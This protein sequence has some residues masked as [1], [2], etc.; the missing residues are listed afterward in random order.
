[1]SDA[2]NDFF[3]FNDG[4]NPAYTGDNNRDRLPFQPSV[5]AEGLIYSLSA[6]KE[7]Q[8]KE[9]AD[10]EPILQDRMKMK[11][12]AAIDCDEKYSKLFA[13]STSESPENIATAAFAKCEPLFAD[14]AEVRINPIYKDGAR[15]ERVSDILEAFRDEA[16]KRTIA[17]VIESRARQKLAPPDA[18]GG[19][20]KPEKGDTGI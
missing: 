4:W 11:L 13:L 17:I 10:L 2:N 14:A 7:K 20:S 3:R 6:I 5:C 15:A 8:K 9:E 18:T 1:L 16:L 12:R 19:V